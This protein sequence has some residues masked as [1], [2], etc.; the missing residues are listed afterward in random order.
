M[1][2]LRN[3]LLGSYPRLGFRHRKTRE[4]HDSLRCPEFTALSHHRPVRRVR[5]FGAFLKRWCT[6]SCQSPG[7]MN[8]MNPGMERGLLSFRHS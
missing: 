1:P 6:S 5:G 2:C 3:V 8:I 7:E 4:F